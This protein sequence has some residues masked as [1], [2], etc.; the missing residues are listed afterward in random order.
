[1]E[2]RRGRVIAQVGKQRH[3]SGLLKTEL[4]LGPSYGSPSASLASVPGLRAT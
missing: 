3:R 1:M 4:C 2:S